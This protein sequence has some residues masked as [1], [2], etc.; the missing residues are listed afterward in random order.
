MHVPLRH[1]PRPEHAHSVPVPLPPPPHGI[2]A[3]LVLP[4]AA[5]RSQSGLAQPG[6]HAHV[7]LAQAPWPEQLPGHRPTAP[8]PAAASSLQFTPAQPGSQ[9]HRD[10]DEF[11]PA[12]V[13]HVPWPPHRATEQLALPAAKAGSPQDGPDHPVSHTQTPSVSSSPTFPA[14]DSDAPPALAGYGLNGRGK[15]RERRAR[16]MTG[17]AAKQPR[18]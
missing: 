7:L 18:T 10:S 14:T 2:S 3:M 11:Q 9:T 15:R 16:D 8:A 6:S 1:F 12:A 5:G 17:R 13:P 4:N